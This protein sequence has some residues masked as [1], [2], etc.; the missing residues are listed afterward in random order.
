MAHYYKAIAQTK[1][2]KNRFHLK[3]YAGRYVCSTFVAIMTGLSLETGIAR[4]AF[5]Q[6]SG[7]F[8]ILLP[9]QN[10]GLNSD[11]CFKLKVPNTQ[12]LAHLS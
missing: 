9:C 11:I 4:H 12:F 1:E 6:I 8:H 10:L 3:S 7:I 2:N 5:L